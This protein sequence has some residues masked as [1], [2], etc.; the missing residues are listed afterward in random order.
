MRADKWDVICQGLFVGF[1][2]YLTVFLGVGAGDLM[3]GNSFFHTF[4]LLGG[5]LFHGLEDPAAVRVWPGAVFAYNGLHLVAFLAFGLF[6][7]WTASVAERGPLLWYGALVLYLFVFLHLFAAVVMMTEP[8]R[9]AFSLLHVAIP[10]LLALG[11]MS[12]VLMYD[13]PQLRREMDEWVDHTD[14]APVAEEE[15]TAAVVLPAESRKET[16]PAHV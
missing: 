7:S 8:M 1:V 14:D 10:S 2:G 6:A 5:W 15:A 16:E 9:S 12:W 11:V 3:K 4:S 13:H